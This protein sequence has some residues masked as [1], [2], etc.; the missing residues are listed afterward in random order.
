MKPKVKVYRYLGNRKGLYN[1][2][3]IDI[4]YKCN[5]EDNHKH[6]IEDIDTFVL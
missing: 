4:E 5:Q 1:A 2:G 6:L 3:N